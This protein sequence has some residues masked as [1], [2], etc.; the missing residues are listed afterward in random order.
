MTGLLDGASRVAEGIKNQGKTQIA[1]RRHAGGDVL[2]ARRA[3]PPQ[4]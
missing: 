4:P 2:R 1:T 3:G